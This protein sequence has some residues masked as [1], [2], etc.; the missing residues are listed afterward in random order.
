[1][2]SHEQFPLDE[3]RKSPEVRVPMEDGEDVV[4]TWENTLI[5]YYAE[6]DGMFDH[7]AYRR[8]DGVGVLF[9]VSPAL[10]ADLLELNFPMRRDPV[11]DEMGITVTFADLESELHEL[12]NEG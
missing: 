12:G 3:S 9:K 5:R 10:H 7:V 6:G 2:T 1:M 11:V 8:D 4:L